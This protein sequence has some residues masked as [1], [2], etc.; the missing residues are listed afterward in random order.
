MHD[1]T[2]STEQAMAGKEN[3]VHNFIEG[4]R[5]SWA[6]LQQH[7]GRT[8]E[9]NRNLFDRI[10]QH[11]SE[12]ITMKSM[13]DRRLRELSENTKPRLSPRMK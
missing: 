3:S 13:D 6:Y 1:M 10:D 5:D 11:L 9:E 2:R 12:T 4:H 7:V 8:A